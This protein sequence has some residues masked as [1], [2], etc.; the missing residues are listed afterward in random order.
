MLHDFF[1]INVRYDNLGV[2][3][4]QG[5]ESNYVIAVMREGQRGAFNEAPCMGN[6]VFD[7]GAPLT[8]GGRH[9]PRAQSLAF[10]RG[11]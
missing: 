2:P 4:A 8:S 3:P 6:V 9:R 7:Y 1:T 5:Q 11:T 10:Q